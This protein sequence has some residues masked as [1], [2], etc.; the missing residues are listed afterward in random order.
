MREYN[1]LVRDKIPEIMKQNGAEPVTMKI[2]STSIIYHLNEKLQEEVNEYLEEGNRVEE[3]VD[4]ATVIM[5]ILEYKGITFYD[6]VR[7][8]SKKL[9][10]KGGFRDKIF[11]VK[12]K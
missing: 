6:F 3:L 8:Y 4:I 7:M 12:E 11:L 9:E 5:A 2:H 1:K 10:N